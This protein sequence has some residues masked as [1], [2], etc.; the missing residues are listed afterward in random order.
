M[1]VQASHTSFQPGSVTRLPA[2]GLLQHGLTMMTP[3]T[4]AYSVPR[5]QNNTSTVSYQ[6]A[7]AAEPFDI[8]RDTTSP[9]PSLGPVVVN[10]SPENLLISPTGAMMHRNHI[11]HVSPNSYSHS[12][13]YGSQLVYPVS[14][15]HTNE[16][17]EA[18]NRYDVY[19][20]PIYTTQLA[21]VQQSHVPISSSIHQSKTYMGSVH[22]PPSKQSPRTLQTLNPHIPSV[23]STTLPAEHVKSIHTLRQPH[24]QPDPS[25]NPYAQYY[26]RHMTVHPDYYAHMPPQNWSEYTLPNALPHSAYNPPAPPSLTSKPP[27][28]HI[29]FKLYGEPPSYN[30]EMH[31]GAV[32]TTDKSVVSKS[33]TSVA[34]ESSNIISSNL[35]NGLDVMR[36][37]AGD[38][39]ESPHACDSGLGSDISSTDNSLQ[40]DSSRSENESEIFEKSDTNYLRSEN[41]NKQEPKSHVIGDD[42]RNR[43]KN[44]Y[45]NSVSITD[46]VDAESRTS[47]R[48]PE[49]SDSG[50]FSTT[51]ISM[52]QSSLYQPLTS[53]PCIASSLPEI[54]NQHIKISNNR[55]NKVKRL[56]DRSHQ[57]PENR[58]LGKH[59]SDLMNDWFERNTEHPY[60]TQKQKRELAIAAGI[61]VSQ[62]SSWFNNKRNRTNNTKPK[63]KHEKL[64][65]RLALMCTELI[66]KGCTEQ[67]SNISLSYDDVK[68]HLH[69]AMLKGKENRSQ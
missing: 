36:T 29:A 59:A 7:A 48:T 4:S 44:L 43:L 11:R 1:S 34:S 40:V 45:S 35:T 52:I 38:C 33:E 53:T 12:S 60:P 54:S 31:G 69:D 63:R 57:K 19:D 51:D 13:G 23:H 37:L 10:K 15:Q 56:S 25:L 50:I 30:K 58:L 6:T 47:T 28:D 39:N 14:V 61:A 62:V 24:S 22:G 64:E 9:P 26:Q 3:V 8:W 67:S 46:L 21:N 65:Q 2:P 66:Q 18:N 5:W 55:T 17:L 68:R 49:N 42:A 20:L 27:H 16:S 41:V 32:H